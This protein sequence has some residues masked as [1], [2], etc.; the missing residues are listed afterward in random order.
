MDFSRFLRPLALALLLT[1]VAAIAQAEPTQ[2]KVLVRANDAKFIG[3]GVGGMN[4]SIT[5]IHTGAVLAQGQITG[6]TGD[7]E[8]LMKAGQPR[9]Q[10]PAGAEAASFQASLDLPQP[11]GVKVSATGPLGGPEDSLQT[12]SATLW[13]LPGQDVTEP[14]LVLQMPGLITDLSQFS[15]DG[16]EISL[17]A[18]VTMMCGCP[19]TKDGLWD[20]DNFNATARLYRNGEQVA[21]QALSFTG[22]KNQFAGKL[23]APGPGDYSLA[24]QAYQS[25]TGNAGFYQRRVS[26]P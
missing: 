11:T 16:R 21:E 10:S 4:V 18:Q 25:T 5:D 13:L 14:G 17:T 26:V 22:E 1:G 20:S 19:I 3:S 15:Q 8:A 24:V 2:L 6:G 12:V 23:T 7:T 9:G